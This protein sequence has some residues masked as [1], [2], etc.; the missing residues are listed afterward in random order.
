MGLAHGGDIEGYRLLHSTE[1]LDF[2]SN[3]NPFGT[4][5]AVR[6]AIARA[7]ARADRYPD[8]LCRR[9]TAAIAADQGVD[10]SQV[11]AGNGAADIIFRLAHALH[12]KRALVCA[13][14][15]DEY[16]QALA[17][18][19][20][21]VDHHLL[22][23]E[24][25]WEVDASLADALL[26]DHDVLFVCNPN[27]P[28]GLVV[29]PDTMAAIEDRCRELDVLLA[30]DECFLGFVDGWR[31]LTMRW[32]V[33]SNPGLVV[34][35]AF[36]KLYGMAG[37]RLGYCLASDIELVEKMRKA[38]Q[39]WSVSLIAQEAGIAAI[40]ECEGYLRESLDEIRTERSWLLEQL[41]S[42]GLAPLLG[43]ADYL[44]FECDVADLTERMESHGILIR[45]CS[46]YAGLGPGAYR[47]AVR[48]HNANERLIAALAQE[49]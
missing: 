41:Q 45:D 32:H 36:T 34:F 7:A 28:T 6:E 25:G 24:D 48:R 9:L 19:G 22:H 8:P 5:P 44:F 17:T 20:C 2:S 29:E 47:I 15:F 30:V 4:P 21:A 1:P 27:N 31:D 49:L 23:R 14:T 43:R 16:E 18:V 42:L 46:N 3:A 26:P 40:E 37:V 38:W 35:D 39:P 33:A 13:P 11:L 12:P 10:P